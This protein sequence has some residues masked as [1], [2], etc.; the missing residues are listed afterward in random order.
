MLKAIFILMMMSKLS[1]AGKD[2]YNDELK[3]LMTKDENSEHTIGKLNTF[4]Q[5]IFTVD[6]NDGDLSDLL[7]KFG[8][9]NNGTYNI[10]ELFKHKNMDEK[11]LDDEFSK[12]LSKA[13]N[14]DEF[15]NNKGLKQELSQFLKRL[16]AFKAY[17]EW[18]EFIKNKNNDQ[19]FKLKST[20]TSIKSYIKEIKDHFQS[21]HEEA[22]KKSIIHEINYQGFLRKLENYMN[23]KN[24]A[25]GKLQEAI[26]SIITGN[27]KIDRNLDGSK[28]RIISLTTAM[29]KILIDGGN[30]QNNTNN[31]N[32]NALKFNKQIF[33]DNIGNI[34]KEIIAKGGE[35]A[36]SNPENKQYEEWTSSCINE[37]LNVDID[38]GSSIASEMIKNIF[39]SNNEV[40]EYK[41]LFNTYNIDEISI[42]HFTGGMTDA[43]ALQIIDYIQLMDDPTLNESWKKA[44][45]NNFFDL[46]RMD[47]NSV[48]LIGVTEKM[49]RLIASIPNIDHNTK[50]EALLASYNIRLSPASSKTDNI[51]I[52]FDKE[53]KNAVEKLPSIND[54]FVMLKVINL[55]EFLHDKENPEILFDFDNNQLAKANELLNDHSKKLEDFKLILQAINK[56]EQPKVDP[57]KLSNDKLLTNIRGSENSKEDIRKHYNDLKTSI[58]S[59]NTKNRRPKRFNQKTNDE[60][61]DD[62]FVE[63]DVDS[64][65]DPNESLNDFDEDDLD[66]KEPISPIKKKSTSDLYSD[67]E[68]QNLLNLMPSDPKINHKKI[69]A[70]YGSKPNNLS[71]EEYD[72]IVIEVFGKLSKAQKEKLVKTKNVSIDVLDKSE[73]IID[74]EI[75]EYVYVS[76][77]SHDN[78]CKNGELAK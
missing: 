7:D 78:P 47:R 56:A 75:V 29:K 46:I 70:S 61:G 72:N 21:H 42:E 5:N 68:D 53:L 11:E 12:I 32:N 33:K 66:I 15:L 62:E 69:N 48:E 4:F 64:N 36:S 50:K 13:T 74:N 55:S 27:E 19:D 9:V 51:S 52:L 31:S 49:L 45:V 44:I 3:E 41:E 40:P 65:Y 37:L 10:A 71:Q 20:V 59:N 25:V 2:D 1:I 17:N 77:T 16:I 73:E 30:K 14:I 63:S 34:L 67:I 6:M 39:T 18:F 24:N 22:G 23:F 60:N 35:M 28:R 58:E 8:S 38:T 76:F 57:T 26:I 54:L 43:L